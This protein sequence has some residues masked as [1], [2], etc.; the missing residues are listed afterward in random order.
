MARTMIHRGPDEEGFYV[1]DHAAL[2]H[3]R[4]SIIDL[5]SGQQPMAGGHGR[6]Q[7]VFNG[8]IY[9]FQEIRTEL[10]R[11]GHRFN[12]ASDTEVMLKAYMEWGKNCVTKFNGM[13]AFAIWDKQEKIL[14]A[15]RDRVGKK[16]F[17][18]AWDGQRFAFASELKALLAAGIS[19]KKINFRALDC[20]FSFG[21]IP[22][23]HTIYED[24]SKLPPAHTLT[25]TSEGITLNRYW[26][27]EFEPVVPQTLDEAA[28]ALTS[29]LYDA[30]KCRLIS[31]VPLG[32]FLSGGIDSALVVSVMADILDHP[33][34]THTIGFQEDG[35]NELQ[36]A[37]T[38]AGFLGTEHREFT[39]DA[40]AWGTIEKIGALLD[41]PFADASVLP[42]W[43]VCRMARQNVT[44][45]LSGDGGD[46]GFGG[47]T[48]RY[49]PH[50]LESRIRKKIPAVFRST[51]FAAL[52][53]LYPGTARLPR[54]LRWKTILEN[55]AVSDGQA[56]YNDL[57]W[58]R[59][60]LRQTLYS[61]DFM[62]TLRGFSPAEMVVPVYRGCPAKDPVSR[63]QST[64]IQ[65]YMT[66]D[67]LVKVD[68]MSMAHSL[69]VRN[70]LLDY[71]ILEFA[72]RLP[73]HLKTA[74]GTGKVLLRHLVGRRLPPQIARLPK[75]GFALPAAKWLQTD[76]KPVVQEVM[77]KS[78]IVR[79]CLN[80][81]EL[82]RLW[83]AHQTGARDHS[84]LLWGLMMLGIWEEQVHERSA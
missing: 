50:L 71:R 27:L 67:V 79:T 66:D 32:A 51:M 64:D 69:E 12:T 72:A 33:V 63:C 35:F 6:F 2:G 39:V 16:P 17:Y 56:F 42:T 49:V 36:A 73:C 80:R 46:E 3:K 20:Y 74:R 14:F 70:P 40:D 45:A 75:K 21:Y 13:F 26:H 37:G 18:Y 1:D 25:V 15:A 82:D 84:V 62:G 78:E 77:R 43:H 9:N 29:L 19:E 53:S 5:S 11:K 47:Y 34:L 28:E 4:L 59:P 57:A 24:I 76:L 22:V 81:S 38:I 54:Y 10:S 55:L 65:V 30:V 41:E 83:Q 7:I 8:E 61:P 44:V 52:G 68:R 58:L 48:F 23:P 60:D 31:E